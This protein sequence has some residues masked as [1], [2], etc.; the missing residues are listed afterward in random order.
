MNPQPLRITQPIILRLDLHKHNLPPLRAPKYQIRNS[1][2]PLLIL[3]R[4]N[5]TDRRQRLATKTLRDFNQ[6]F[7]RE[8]PVYADGTGLA[9]GVGGVDRADEFFGGAVCYFDEAVVYFGG[10]GEVEGVCV[11]VEGAGLK[12]GLKNIGDV[13]EENVVE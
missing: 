1:P 9:R 4:Q 5:L 6:V 13:G 7:Q 2:T 10:A 12:R 11:E 8:G 3:L